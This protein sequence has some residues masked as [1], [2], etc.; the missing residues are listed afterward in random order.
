MC[1]FLSAIVL[2]NGDVLHNPYTDSHE[3]L[4][5][6]FNLR[7]NREGNF[8]RV[9]FSPPTSDD[10]DKPEKYKFKVDEHRTPD[11]LT[12]A[13]QEKAASH[14]RSVVK[15]MI[16]DKPV[17]GLCGGAY[18]LTKGANV[19]W[20]RA[21]RVLVMRGNSRVGEMWEN[22]RVG[23]MWGN[24]RVGEM[25]GNSKVGE[26]WGNSKVGAMSENSKVG[27]MSE[28]SR[29]GEMWGNSRVGEMWGNSKVGE[30]WGNS[31][32]G[33]M[34]ENSKVGAMSENSQVVKDSRPEK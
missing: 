7:D 15:R 26:M 31:K 18:I 30:M 34:S 29:V 28:N 22:S 33:A 13:K 23:E 2:R 20:A 27:A 32:V 16:I 24:S 11:W 12:K 10:F 4:I 19:S 5:D 17:K 1:N 8:A 14:L 3:E 25:W 9:E 21:C 6:L